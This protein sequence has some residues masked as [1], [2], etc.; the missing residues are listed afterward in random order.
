[1]TVLALNVFCV[2][3]FCFLFNKTKL[4]RRGFQEALIGSC[5]TQRPT[6]SLMYY[7]YFYESPRLKIIRNY[8]LYIVDFSI[9]PNI[10][11]R[12]VDYNVD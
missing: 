7:V 3:I 5:A 4:R 10:L 2:A 11:N 1:M 6:Y 9:I 8:P 12:I